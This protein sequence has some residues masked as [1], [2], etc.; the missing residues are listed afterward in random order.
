MGQTLTASVD[1]LGDVSHSY[2]WLADD[3]EIA[4]ATGETYV[5]RAEDEGKTIKVRVDFTDGDGNPQ[6]LTSAP[7]AEVVLG[8]L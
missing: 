2:Q 4:G 6:S 7:T 1:G 5:V 3:V 8:G